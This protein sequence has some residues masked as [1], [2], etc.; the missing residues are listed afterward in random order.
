MLYYD[1]VHT[2]YV[3]LK[4]GDLVRWVTDWGIYAASADGHIEREFPQYAYGII[5]EVSHQDPDAIVV[6]CY[7]SK[8]KF[9]EYNM[10]VI[11]HM[12][13]DEF[14]LVSQA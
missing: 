11:L 4:R 5:M 14:E 8:Q 6:Y 9:T 1:Q 7:D 10:W 13:Q 12:I 3:E 2:Y